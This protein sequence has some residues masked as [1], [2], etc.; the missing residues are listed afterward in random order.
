MTQAGNCIRDERS[1]VIVSDFERVLVLETS[2]RVGQVALASGDRVLAEERLA[3]AH[4]RASDLAT[5]VQRLLT[6]QSW[7]AHELTAVIVGLGPGSYTGLRVGLASAKAL[8]YASGCR[9]FGVETFAAIALRGASIHDAITVIADALQGKLFVRDYSQRDDAFA[10]T[11]P[12][13][14]VQAADWIGSRSADSIVTGP[15]AKAFSDRLPTADETLH[16]PRPIDLLRVAQSC[17]W[18]VN[19]D[20][21][22]AEPL[23]L[24]GSSAEEKAMNRA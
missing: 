9:F 19:P 17:P 15:A 10:P 12:L 20:V 11:T 7:K 4:R 2:G 24:R 3:E 23:Y 22:Q 18:A 14:I 5:T 6:A 21:W 1:G 8:A 13:R 16:E